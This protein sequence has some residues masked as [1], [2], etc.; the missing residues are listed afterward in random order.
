VISGVSGL[1]EE[2]TIRRHAATRDKSVVFAMVNSFTTK[3]DCPIGS[4][5][6]CF[7]YSLLQRKEIYKIYKCQ[8]SSA[9]ERRTFQDLFQH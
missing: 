5:M 3:G 8:V 6:E 9:L 7:K 4:L 2:G 1:A